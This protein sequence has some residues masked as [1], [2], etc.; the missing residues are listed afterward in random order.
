MARKRAILVLPDAVPS[1]SVV[2]ARPSEDTP[3]SGSDGPISVHCA[4]CAGLLAT[5]LR[6]HEVMNVVVECPRCL[7]LNLVR[8]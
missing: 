8:V 6:P 7:R 3:L 5:S 4:A 2:R 1:G